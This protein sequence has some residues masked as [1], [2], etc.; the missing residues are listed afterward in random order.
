MFLTH[1]EV[2]RN[3]APKKH[4][5]FSQKITSQWGEGGIAQ[6]VRKIQKEGAIAQ[7]A[8]Q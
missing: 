6:I 1:K 7:F 4:I 2:Y 3:R 8:Q 5:I